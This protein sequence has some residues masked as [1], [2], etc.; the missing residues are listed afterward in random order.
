MHSNN[1]YTY[2]YE[3]FLSIYIYIYASVLRGTFIIVISIKYYYMLHSTEAVTFFKRSTEGF[4]NQ[5]HR[6]DCWLKVHGDLD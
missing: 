3:I 1:T 5:F 2:I 4:P 6:Q